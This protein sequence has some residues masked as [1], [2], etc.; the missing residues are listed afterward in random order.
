MK[1]ELVGAFRPTSLGLRM[2]Y[3]L[4]FYD[5]KVPWKSTLVSKNVETSDNKLRNETCSLLIYLFTNIRR[6]TIIMSDT[7]LGT[8]LTVN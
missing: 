2:K 5:A 4:I 6:H 8:T 7:V 3:K 1:S